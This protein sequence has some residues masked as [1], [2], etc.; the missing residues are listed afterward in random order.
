MADTGNRD[1]LGLAVKLLET[2]PESGNGQIG[3][4]V[5]ADSCIA[6]QTGYFRIG[7]QV[8]LFAGGKVDPVFRDNS[9]SGGV[10]SGGEGR[11]ARCSIGLHVIVVGVGVIDAVVDETAESV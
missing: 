4:G 6:L 5:A 11:Q 7:D 10:G 9:V 8:D 3:R 1:H 2:V